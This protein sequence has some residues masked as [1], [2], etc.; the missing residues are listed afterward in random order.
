M[1][2]IDG[3]RLL[4][5]GHVHL[6]AQ[7]HARWYLRIVQ[8]AIKAP[9]ACAQESY[10][11]IHKAMCQ[12]GPTFVCMQPFS[13]TLLLSA[14]LLKHMRL[15]SFPKT[16]N[17]LSECLRCLETKQAALSSTCY[18]QQFDSMSVNFDIPNCCDFY[19]YNT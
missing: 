18:L 14:H 13:V 2:V 12:Q 1:K 19:T 11:A 9:A 6:F 5:F 7:V 3:R 10:P 4:L 17:I 15:P 8:L 16:I